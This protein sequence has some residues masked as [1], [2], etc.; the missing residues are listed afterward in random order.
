MIVPLQNGIALQT[1]YRLQLQ[2]EEHSGPIKC[3]GYEL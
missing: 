1:I 3:R 2:G